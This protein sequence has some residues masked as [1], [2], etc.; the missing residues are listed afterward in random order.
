MIRS[1]AIVLSALLLG[2]SVP[3]SL[4]ASVVQCPDGTPPPCRSAATAPRGTR[5]VAAPAMSVAVPDFENLSRDTNDTYL[6]QGLAEELPLRR[7][8]TRAAVRSRNQ[9]NIHG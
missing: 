8:G 2:A 9:V 1:H 6:S 4:G 5:V 7:N 3:R